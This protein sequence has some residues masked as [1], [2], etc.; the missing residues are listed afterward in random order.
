MTPRA[1]LR[2][3][4]DCTARGGYLHRDSSTVAQRDLLHFLCVA[5]NHFWSRASL[6]DDRSELPCDQAVSMRPDPRSLFKFRA[7]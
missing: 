4:L 5:G 2:D 6:E 7:S 3:I 1:S